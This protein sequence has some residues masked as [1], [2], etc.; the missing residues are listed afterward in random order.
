MPQYR[1]TKVA[2][3]SLLGQIHSQC[4]LYCSYAETRKSKYSIRKR[5]I[6]VCEYAPE[7][8]QLEIYTNN[9]VRLSLS[10]ILRCRHFKSALNLAIP[11]K[12]FKMSI[13]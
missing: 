5:I 11:F 3:E 8:Q 9:L 13:R 12:N 4:K 2:A 10:R 6:K 7:G 1:V